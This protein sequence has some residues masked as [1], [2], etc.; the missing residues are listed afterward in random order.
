MGHKTIWRGEIESESFF[1]TILLDSVVNNYLYSMC[2]DVVEV[3]YHLMGKVS[4][5][6]TD[7]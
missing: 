7:P 3:W 2:D 4:H 1:I 5:Q 6:L